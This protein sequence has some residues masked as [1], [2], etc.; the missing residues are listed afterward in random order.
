MPMDANSKFLDWGAKL[1]D[2]MNEPDP[3][4]CETEVAIRLANGA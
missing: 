2:P 1:K 4:K 3:A